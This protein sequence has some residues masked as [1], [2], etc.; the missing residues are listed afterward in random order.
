MIGL[1]ILLHCGLFWVFMVSYFTHK[2][3]F[4]S[5]LRLCVFKTLDFFDHRAYIFTYLLGLL[6]I[7]FLHIHMNF[8]LSFWVWFADNF[9]ARVLRSLNHTFSFTQVWILVVIEVIS[10]Q[11][12]DI[13]CIWN[14]RIIKWLLLRLRNQEVSRLRHNE[15]LVFLWLLANNFIKWFL[16]L[17]FYRRHRFQKNLRFL[18]WIFSY[19][20]TLIIVFWFFLVIRHQLLIQ[21]ESWASL[22]FRCE[23]SYDW[24]YWFVMCIIKIVKIQLMFIIRV[25][26]LNKL[27]F[28]FLMIII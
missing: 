21:F 2:L 20:P 3:S 9:E 15:K 22:F 26:L 17:S 13:F 25:N 27:N 7:L 12:R 28:R 16:N 19:N 8:R 6:R 24:Q 4:L 14:L 11:I 23:I 1:P 18:I 10:V 5:G